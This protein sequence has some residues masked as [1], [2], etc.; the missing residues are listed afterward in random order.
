MK[1]QFSFATLSI[2]LCAFLF[3]SCADSDNEEKLT[4]GVWV[5][6][7]SDE[8]AEFGDNIKCN[9]LLNFRNNDGYRSLTLQVNGNGKDEDVS[10]DFDITVQGEWQA[11][12]GLLTIEFDI[13][14]LKTNISNI[15]VPYSDVLD[16]N[17]K[18]VIES[19]V[20]EMWT[21]LLKGIISESQSVFD[22]MPYSL[23]NGVLT[24]EYEGLGKDVYVNMKSLQ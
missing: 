17:D 23:E 18:M 20:A 3:S 2:L 8:Y 22:A 24:I 15:R 14:S 21:N 1:K 6:D 11:T 10:Y 12:L 7:A 16:Y 19:E 4:K 5:K 13:E 9:E